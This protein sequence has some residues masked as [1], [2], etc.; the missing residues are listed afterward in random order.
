MKV[1]PSIALIGGL[2][3]CCLFASSSSFAMDAD[4]AQALAKKEGC[5]KCHA[6]DKKKEAK[7]LSEIGKSLKGKPDANA[8]LIHHFTS[9]EKV[10]F[11][12]GK[13]E[14][15]KVMKTKDKA[16]MQNLAEWILSLAK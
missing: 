3:A 9:G 6:V 1:K 8:K 2:W 11:E 12:D 7:S 15:H 16:A 13:E 14:E 10:K 5:L 4:E